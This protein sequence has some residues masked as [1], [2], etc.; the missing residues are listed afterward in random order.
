L[1]AAWCLGAGRD[2][3]RIAAQSREQKAV[4]RHQSLFTFRIEVRVTVL[5]NNASG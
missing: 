1:K 4:S 5:I 2:I 3:D